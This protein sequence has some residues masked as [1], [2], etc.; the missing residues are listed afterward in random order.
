MSGVTLIT[1]RQG[2]HRGYR[3]RRVDEGKTGRTSKVYDKSAT[4]DT[5]EELKRF[6]RIEQ[7]FYNP[8]YLINAVDA[9]AIKFI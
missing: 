3:I 8:R 2:I 7:K 1:S 6:L 9:R 5:D 4:L